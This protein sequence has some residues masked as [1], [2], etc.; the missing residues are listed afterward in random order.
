MCNLK[1][2]QATNRMNENVPCRESVQASQLLLVVMGHLS[3]S[4]ATLSKSFGRT[5]KAG[6]ADA[7]ARISMYVFVPRRLI[8]ERFTHIRGRIVLL[9][10]HAMIWG[11]ILNCCKV[12][13]LFILAPCCATL[14]LMSLQ[15]S[16]H[17]VVDLA[18]PL[19][20]SLLFKFIVQF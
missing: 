16:A 7:S 17:I 2:N 15:R 1:K 13:V 14:N 18:I 20:Y 5:L 3:S 11:R 4:T 12:N 8:R 6:K 9:V 10:H 19:W